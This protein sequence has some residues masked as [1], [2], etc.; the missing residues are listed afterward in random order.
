[1]KCEA[2]SKTAKYSILLATGPNEDGV[3][4]D[5]VYLP[6]QSAR[7]VGENAEH[8]FCPECMRTLEDNFRSTLLYLQVENRLIS[9]VPVAR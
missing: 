7:G 9:P 1:M 2:C 5:R 6:N 3:V 4:V 8:W